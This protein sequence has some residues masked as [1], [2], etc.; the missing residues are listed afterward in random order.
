MGL[1]DTRPPLVVRINTLQDMQGSIMRLKKS[2]DEAKTESVQIPPHVR[3][4]ELR[5]LADLEAE[6]SKDTTRIQA[7]EAEVRK[8]KA[9]NQSHTAKLE[10]LLQ[11][12]RDVEAQSHDAS[13]RLN[14]LD[15]LF[16][17]AF[18]HMIGLRIQLNRANAQLEEA[19]R[20]NTQKTNKLKDRQIEIEKQ[21]K[22]RKDLQAQI[23]RYQESIECLS[24]NGAASNTKIIELQKSLEE[25]QSQA[26][27]LQTQTEN[28]RKSLKTLEQ[29]AST[30]Q[31]KIGALG[32]K[33]GDTQS[34]AYML[35]AQ[36][37]SEHA[38]LQD[39]Q[40]QVTELTAK[41]EVA[42][43]RE[44]RLEESLGFVAQTMLDM[45]GKDA[46][47]AGKVTGEQVT[48]SADVIAEQ[49][50][51]KTLLEQLLAGQNCE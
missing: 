33:L 22:C 5:K 31:S 3:D 42:A 15:V 45:I 14:T 32:E 28:D 11:A 37:E 7:L 24:R 9:Q 8:E 17:S 49:D 16:G 21:E 39:S 20:T 40:T 10:T 27:V 19:T 38:K 35:H 41:L 13:E 29:E 43:K 50:G 23:E 48:K 46:N 44:R 26:K 2:Y 25:W 47:P 12:V 1:W 6:K 18:R 30:Q 36:N 34:L 51:L 4:K